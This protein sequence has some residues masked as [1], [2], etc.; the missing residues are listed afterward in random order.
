M[1][2]VVR[3]PGQVSSL[4]CVQSSLSLFDPHH[5]ALCA[6]RHIRPARLSGGPRFK[7]E[8]LSSYR[9]ETDGN[10]GWRKIIRCSWF[11]KW[12]R[13]SISYLYLSR[14]H[15]AAYHFDHKVTQC[16]GVHRLHYSIGL[17]ICRM[18]FQEY[19]RSRIKVRE[20]GAV[21][22]PSAAS[23]PQTASWIYQYTA[24]SDY[25]YMWEPWSGP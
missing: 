9:G 4:G 14:L 6:T 23:A 24:Q 18:Y 20:K 16:Y 25:W 1:L 17:S 2:P 5:G 19:C 12:D 15:V 3:L 22:N 10:C 11:V 13:L 7:H 8:Q 21:T